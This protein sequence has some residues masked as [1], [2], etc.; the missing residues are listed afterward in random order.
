MDLIRIESF[1]WPLNENLAQEAAYS[2]GIDGKVIEIDIPDSV[3]ND[4]IDKKLFEE[5][6]YDLGIIQ[7]SG[8][9]VVIKKEGIKILNN[10]VR[11]WRY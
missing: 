6:P 4:C 3:Y 7:C 11:D 10:Y 9:E 1:S 8:R 2:Y 5:R